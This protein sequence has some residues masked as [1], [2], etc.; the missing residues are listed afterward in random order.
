ME[1][2]VLDVI[3]ESILTLIK[4]STPLL[5][6]ALLVGLIISIFQTAT[7]IQ[8]QTLAFVPKILAVFLGIIVFGGWILSTLIS[9]A[10]NIFTNLEMFL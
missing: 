3:R 6:L 9:F 2:L 7:S 4:V 8:E 5:M 10:N 1:Q